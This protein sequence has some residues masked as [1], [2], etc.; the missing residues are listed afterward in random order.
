MYELFN[1]VK[2]YTMIYFEELFNLYK[3]A[4][5]VQKRGVPGAI[6]EC[7]V[8]NG[9]SAAV[10]ASAFA[11]SPRRLLW[12]YDNFDGLPPADPEDGAVAPLFTGMFKGTVDN[13]GKVL[14]K[15]GFPPE[16][17]VLRNG[18]FAHTFAQ[19]LPDQV[20]LLHINSDWYE[21]E[22][23]SLKTFYPR[24]PD[25]GVVI[26]GDYGYW[27]GARKAFYAF[28]RECDAEPLLERQGVEQ[29]YWVKGREHNRA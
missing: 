11:A 1:L 5:A 26:L 25:G 6:V 12:L 22:L 3:L 21:S 17:V 19:P 9:G 16:R 8:C 18:L 28:C 15:V 13:V 29:A 2:P 10:L 14:A 23:L 4:C 24:M 20:A 27:E 7:G